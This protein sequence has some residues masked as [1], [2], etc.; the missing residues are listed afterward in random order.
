MSLRTK[1]LLATSA[2]IAALFAVLFIAAWLIVLRGFTREEGRLTRENVSRAVNA[3]DREL[4]GLLSGAKDY[5][6]WDDTY[7]FIDDRNEEYARENLSDS[8]LQNLGLSVAAWINGSGAVVFGAAFD[9]GAETSRALNIEEAASLTMPERLLGPGSEDLDYSGLM[10]VG[11]QIALV[12]GSP[13]LRRGSGGPSRGTL[14]FGR[15]LRSGE[16]SAL[17]SATNMDLDIFDGD[18]RVLPGDVLAAGTSIG[19]GGEAAVRV[20]SKEKIG[21]Y[22]AL[23]DME[24]GASFILRVEMPRTVYQQG[25][26]TLVGLFAALAGLAILLVGLLVFLLDRIVLARLGRLTAGM[27][28]IGSGQ[29]PGALV[30]VE[31]RDE[32]GALGA[33]LNHL[34]ESLEGE[35]KE[36]NKVEWELRYQKTLLESQA[37]ASIDGIF[38]VDPEGRWLSANSRFVEMWGIPPEVA[39]RKDRDA[40]LS[41][42][43]RNIENPQEFLRR[44][45]EIYASPG[46]ES[47][48][49]IK[50][51]D[52]RALDRYSAP[53]RDTSGHV[54]GRVWFYRD[55]TDQARAEELVLFQKTLLES[56]IET[57]PDA[58]AVVNAHRRVILANR[59][60]AELCDV[61]ER[62]THRG[63]GSEN[64]RAVSQKAADPDAF[65]ARL[66]QLYRD[67][68]LIAHDEVLFKDGR[69]F[70]RY[71]SPVSGPEGQYYGRVW[72]YR[73]ITERKH[74]EQYLKRMGRITLINSI[75]RAVAEQSEEQGIHEVVAR[76]LCAGL[77]A[78]ACVV[79][80][81]D[82]ESSRFVPTV[83]M[84]GST[85]TEAGL[86]MRTGG[87]LDMDS[88]NLKRAAGGTV[89]IMNDTST[90]AGAFERGIE[91]AGLRS[92]LLVPLADEGKVVGAVLVARTGRHA[93]DG[94]DA[95]VLATL[96]GHVAL[97]V[98]DARL[99]AHLQKAYDD[100]KRAQDAAIQQERLRALGEMAS[101][102]AH[103]INNAL[104]PVIGFA[105]LLMARKEQFDEKSQ[106]FLG[107]MRTSAVDITHIIAR[108]REFYRKPDDRAE[109][110]PVD[111]DALVKQVVLLTRPRWRDMAVQRGAE[112]KVTAE[113][114]R[115][116]PLIMGHESELREA[117]TNLVINAVDAL[118]AGGKVR[119]RGEIVRDTQGEPASVCLEVIDTGV[120]MDEAT[121]KR[122]L[123]P[124]FT[125]KGD[126][127]TGLGLAVVSSV[128]QRHGGRLEIDSAP[129]KGTTMRM[130]LPMN[131]VTKPAGGSI[132]QETPKTGPKRL[133]IVDDE[134]MLREVLSEMLGG[135]GHHLTVAEGG[136]EAIEEFEKSLT[137]GT[138][139]DAVITDL[140]MPGVDGRTVAVTVKKLSP[141]TPVMILSGWGSDPEEGKA[142]PKEVDAILGKPP[143]LAELR[144]ELARITDQSA[145]AA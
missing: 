83:I 51:N 53:V 28:A 41:V 101:G 59:R 90:T 60:V 117:M 124:F 78:A 91:A 127:G 3:L 15:F 75:T 126:K 6:R 106:R 137:A 141:A 68:E 45:E 135:E 11:G 54:Y 48:D 85:G 72:Y 139:Y 67:P 76:Q 96:C 128:M 46:V 37:E 97:S 71:T 35:R 10:R 26:A 143:R 69:A 30:K 88:P 66:E 133:L 110:T 38:T 82:R 105:D 5:A 74:A 113:I 50:L 129:G 8:V 63:D 13:V 132:E 92:F 23:P 107:I 17:A 47:R 4:E 44:I 116:T 34:L 142:I 134:P 12:A 138:P 39:E 22:A 131:P 21:G 62:P 73:D 2:A 94:A 52:G 125:T 98:R 99:R 100:L 58:I 33:T 112:I 32:V 27:R 89:S 9:E 102:I 31:G 64:F 70:D 1:T 109:R 136:R 115:G 104:S 93:F 20:L 118:P 130:V 111:F 49:R 42:A 95:E 120:G 40:A 19:T 119:I 24:G 123:E 56:Q 43:T 140:G 65:S 77:P 18:T 103:D 80:A 61:S 87:P 55:I 7:S 108:M 57:A 14:I 25:R 16:I 86:G 121:V 36:R 144:A 145:M 29:G 84:Q 79:F 114:P 81:L 122:C